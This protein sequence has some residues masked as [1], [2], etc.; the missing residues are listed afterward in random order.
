MFLSGRKYDDSLGIEWPDQAL[1]L[2]RINCT[3][4][5]SGSLFIRIESDMDVG[6]P[7]LPSQP[8]FDCGQGIDPL[9]V[10]GKRR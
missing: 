4:G 10:L 2:E 5:H 6:C 8:L 9:Y 3:V 1:A 7:S